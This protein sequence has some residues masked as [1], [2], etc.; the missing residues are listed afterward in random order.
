MNHGQNWSER[1]EKVLD[2]DNRECQFCGDTDDLQ[3]H[4]ISPAREFRSHAQ[5]NQRENL[6]TLCVGCHGKLEPFAPGQQRDVLRR[7]GLGQ[8]S[9]GDDK[10]EYLSNDPPTPN[11]KADKMSGTSRPRALLTDAERKAVRQDPEMD[12]SARST[13]RSRIR[14][15]LDRLRE[16]VRL[17]RQHRPEIYNGAFDVFVEEE[18]NQRI[19]RLEEEVDE[20]QDRLEDE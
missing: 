12:T 2:R 4:H 1:R 18:L 20:L 17:L 13:H 5:A 16:D 11:P 7:H 14:G 8:P 9:D 6:V 15:K 10:K 3:V 19:E